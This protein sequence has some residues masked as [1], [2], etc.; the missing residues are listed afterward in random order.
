MKKLQK[1]VLWKKIQVSSFNLMRQMILFC[2]IQLPFAMWICFRAWQH[3]L[4]S[5]A[6]LTTMYPCGDPVL[7][8]LYSVSASAISLFKQ[9]LLWPLTGISLLAWCQLNN[10]HKHGHWNCMANGHI[11]DL[12][13]IFTTVL[14]I[15]LLLIKLS[16]KQKQNKKFYRAL[17]NPTLR[18]TAGLSQNSFGWRTKPFIFQFLFTYPASSQVIFLH[19]TCA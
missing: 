9:H 15:L 16:L 6:I 19:F 11:D 13:Y 3:R 8:S 18:N 2:E 5:L 12:E 4:F 14:L 17:V 10:K 1:K 7:P